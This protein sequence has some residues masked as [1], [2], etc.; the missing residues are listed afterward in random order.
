MNNYTYEIV[1]TACPN[2]YTI[3]SPK[4]L[5]IGELL[6]KLGEQEGESVLNHFYRGD[7]MLVNIAL[8]DNPEVPIGY[9]SLIP[10]DPGDEIILIAA[11]DKDGNRARIKIIE[12]NNDNN[13][14]NVTRIFEDS[15]EAIEMINFPV[16][17]VEDEAEKENIKETL[18]VGD[19]HDFNAEEIGVS[20]Y[21]SSGTVI[22]FES[23]NN[24]HFEKALD[25]VY[26]QIDVMDL[27]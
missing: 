17:E 11:E 4:P 23:L 16:V 15:I 3:N 18:V 10:G 9:D 24:L 5:T 6:I 19:T 21:L 7:K 12:D 8:I 22:N 27:I 25:S 1:Y 26:K 14:I 2:D 13:S 20:I